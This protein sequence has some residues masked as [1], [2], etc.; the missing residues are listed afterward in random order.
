MARRAITQEPDRPQDRCRLDR[1]VHEATVPG[2]G[3]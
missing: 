3:R 1:V 2:V